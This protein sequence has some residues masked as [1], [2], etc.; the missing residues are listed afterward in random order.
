RNRTCKRHKFFHLFLP[1]LLNISEIESLHPV[2]LLY[3]V[4]S[5]ELLQIGPSTA[6][7]Q[8]VKITIPAAQAF[9]FFAKWR[10]AV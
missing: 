4:I 3:L 5:F 1:F 10:L 2:A 8:F 7:A 6:N 9:L